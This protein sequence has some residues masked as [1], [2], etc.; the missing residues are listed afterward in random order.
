MKRVLLVVV[1]VAFSGS[2]TGCE[3]IGKAMA[4]K[5][6]EELQAEI[7]AKDER[8]VALEKLLGV[9][10]GED[11]LEAAGNKKWDGLGSLFKRE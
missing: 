10:E 2:L 4:K 7:A 3:R 11:V 1:L 9:E 8:I 5:H 6:I